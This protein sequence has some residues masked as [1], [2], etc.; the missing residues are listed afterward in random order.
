MVSSRTPVLLRARCA[1]RNL[2]LARRNETESRTSEELLIPA[3]DESVVRSSFTELSESGR[4]WSS[5]RSCAPWPKRRDTLARVRGGQY[6]KSHACS[7]RA[8]AGHIARPGHVA[9]RGNGFRRFA[10]TSRGYTSVRAERRDDVAVSVQN[11]RHGE[12]NHARNWVDRHGAV[13]QITNLTVRP[14]DDV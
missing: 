7:Y 4:R 11:G 13:D 9:R 2:D 6:R 8:R 12:R 14:S 1:D 10:R 3:L 5:S